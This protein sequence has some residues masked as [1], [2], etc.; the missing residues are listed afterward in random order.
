MPAK[1]VPNPEGIALFRASPG[2]AA[3]L[4]I[5]AQ[6]A[7]DAAKLIA[8]IASEPPSIGEAGDYLRG[9]AAHSGVD[10]GRALARV[11]GHDFKSV[12]IEFG[13][14]H[15]PVYA[16][17]RRACESVGLHIEADRGA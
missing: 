7:V 1:F 5:H 3:A 6:Q 4:Q 10:G 15:M 11:V 2:I 13:S 16:V 9:L 17:L 8:P 14:I 12:W